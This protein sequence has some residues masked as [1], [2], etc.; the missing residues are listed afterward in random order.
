[1]LTAKDLYNLDHNYWLQYRKPNEI[2]LGN[3]I[4]DLKE[5]QNDIL[6]I[7]NENTHTNLFISMWNNFWNGDFMSTFYNYLEIFQISFIAIFIL[8]IALFFPRSGRV[9][10]FLNKLSFEYIILV[11]LCNSYDGVFRT[12]NLNFAAENFK[13]KDIKNLSDFF[14]KKDWVTYFNDHANVLQFDLFFTKLFIWFSLIGLAITFYGLADRFFIANSYDIEFT[15]LVYLMY[16]GSVFLFLAHNFFEFLLGLEVIT[17][18]SYALAAYERKSKFSAYAG[19]QYF[20]IGSIPSGLLV[21]S[22]A[23]MYK[24]WGTLAFSD[25]DVILNKMYSNKRAVHDTS[26]FTQLPKQIK[27]NG[28][29]DYPYT[30]PGI[31][32]DSNALTAEETILFK[33]YRESKEDLQFALHFQLG[34]TDILKRKLAVMNNWDLGFKSAYG[35]EYDK[36]SGYYNYL[37]IDCD[38]RYRIYDSPNLRVFQNHLDDKEKMANQLIDWYSLFGEPRTLIENPF[39]G[40]KKIEMLFSLFLV[41]FNLFFKITAAPFNFWA[42]SV[43]GKA[44]V[45]STTFLSIYSKLAVVFALIKVLWT[46]FVHFK[47]LFLGLFILMGILSMLFG[48]A[49]AF[50]EK[51][52]KRFFVYS[53]MGHVGYLVVALSLSTTSGFAAVFHYLFVYVVSSYLMWFVLIIMGRSRNN[54]AHFGSLKNIDKWVATAFALLVFSMSGLPPLGG[55][56][57][58]LDVLVALLETSQFYVNF[59]LLFFSV[60]SFFYYLRLIKIIYFDERKDFIRDIYISE[61]RLWITV[62][63]FV[64]LVVYMFTIHR[65]LI[66]MERQSLLALLNN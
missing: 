48:M 42:P 27:Y 13:Y 16:F 43:Y 2:R 22:L 60:I 9:T 65:P 52:T 11:L 25:I 36:I 66:I 29:W 21:L 45:S 17:L 63:L 15:L 28:F 51:T 57:I 54:L 47:E 19:V 62:V 39:V 40:E 14:T 35:V 26:L 6:I 41:V 46:L 1:M 64:T 4:F 5:E 32:G 56:F 49:G 20:I 44:P 58:K 10:R 61:E 33:G 37:K 34:S 59:L 23:L 3:I 53:S 7:S 50:V 18:G 24:A 38:G 31:F 8:L 12:Y 55:F 30:Y